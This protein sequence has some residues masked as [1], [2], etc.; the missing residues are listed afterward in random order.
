M[1]YFPLISTGITESTTHGGIQ[2]TWNER[3]DF[4]LLFTKAQENRS[5]Y[6]LSEQMRWLNKAILNPFTRLRLLD[7]ACSLCPANYLAWRDLIGFV[8][9]DIGYLG[10]DLTQSFDVPKHWLIESLKAL[11][12]SES[13]DEPVVSSFACHV[14]ASSENLC[15]TK[16]ENVVDGTSSE[17]YVRENEGNFINASISVKK[18]RTTYLSFTVKYIIQIERSYVHDLKMFVF[19]T[20]TEYLILCIFIFFIELCILNK[21]EMLY[22]LS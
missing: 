4:Q 11:E 20:E 17:F 22:N 2:W 14:T 19:L 18:N 9:D 6:I 21:F 16:P 1:W 13:Q 7:K 10:E 8:S 12:I 15:S 3:C 5:K